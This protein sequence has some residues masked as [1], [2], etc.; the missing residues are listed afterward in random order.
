MEEALKPYQL[1]LRKIF[2]VIIVLIRL[3]LIGTIYVQY[4]WM[5]TMLMDKQEEFKSKLI[6]GINDVGKLLME[7]KGTLPSLKNYRSQPGF[8]WPSEQ[9]QMELMKPPTI[10]QKFTEFEVSEKL[11]KAIDSHVMKNV[12]YEFAITSNV[13]LLAYELKSKNF[14]NEIKDQDNNLILYYIFQPPSGSDLENLV[15]EEIMTVV[16][17]NWKQ[18]SGEMQWMIVGAI[19]FTLM[20]ISA[21]YVTVNALLRQKKVSEIKNDFINNMTHEFK[22]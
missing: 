18:I 1:Q 15:P 6:N 2:P 12:Q 16:V 20:I 21:F 7:Q 22:T 14:L 19:F 13:N 8:N 9:F 17:P 11:H 3:S 5:R 10:A 4:S